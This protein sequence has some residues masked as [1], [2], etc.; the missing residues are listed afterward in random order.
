MLTLRV[1]VDFFF[2]GLLTLSHVRNK[3]MYIVLLEGELEESVEEL[4]SMRQ[5]IATLR[6]QKDITT[7]KPVSLAGI[8]SEDSENIEQKPVQGPKGLETTI[9]EAKVC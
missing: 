8:K 2:L 7:G 9:E 4:Q 6:N 3:L 1:L 5:K